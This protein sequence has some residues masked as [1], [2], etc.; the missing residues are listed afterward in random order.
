M[1]EVKLKR[2][3]RNMAMYECVASVDG[4]PVASADILCAEGGA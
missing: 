2:V 4:K 1:L 3:I